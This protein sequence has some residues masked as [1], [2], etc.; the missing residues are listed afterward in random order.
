MNTS[1]AKRGAKGLL[2]VDKP[3]RRLLPLAWSTR[4]R[5]RTHR[6]QLLP[7]TTHAFRGCP[8][9]E[10]PKAI[11]R[12]VRTSEPQQQRLAECGTTITRLTSRAPDIGGGV[13]RSGRLASAGG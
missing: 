13:P 4:V 11:A 3:R 1:L 2:Y 5:L 8:Q 9:A 10:E 7:R 6:Y 12:L